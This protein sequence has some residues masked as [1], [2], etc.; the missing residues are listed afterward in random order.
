MNKQNVGFKIMNLAKKIEK[1]EE[2]LKGK[3]IVIAFSEVQIV[4]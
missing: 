4:H 3:D 1:V 2:I